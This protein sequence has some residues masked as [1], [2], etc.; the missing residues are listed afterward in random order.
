VNVGESHFNHFSARSFDCGEHA[1][2]QDQSY[3]AL[4][5]IK[6]NGPGADDRAVDR[7]TTDRRAV[8]AGRLFQQT[9]ST[10]LSRRMEDAGRFDCLTKIQV[11][12]GMK[13]ATTATQQSGTGQQQG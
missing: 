2:A 11:D 6:T 7:H 13:S 12:S 8:K 9:H 1:C 5:M 3:A 10:A 4:R